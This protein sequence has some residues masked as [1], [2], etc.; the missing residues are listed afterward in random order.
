[1]M[2]HFSLN[3]PGGARAEVYYDECNISAQSSFP[4]SYGE[5]MG[6]LSYTI[7]VASGIELPKAGLF[8]DSLDKFISQYLRTENTMDDLVSAEERL[9]YNTP[10]TDEDL[11]RVGNAPLRDLEEDLAYLF[12]MEGRE[13][14]P[15]Q[16]MLSVEER[17]SLITALESALSQQV[18]GIEQGK[19]YLTLIDKLK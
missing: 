14:D 13:P 7:A 3:F 17:T 18:I 10:V 12:K 8:V 2:P 16:Y 5:F 6:V 4:L 15:K 19:S 11:L 1:M 9:L